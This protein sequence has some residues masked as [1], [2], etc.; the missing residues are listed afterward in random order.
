MGLTEV[1]ALLEHDALARRVVLHEPRVDRV[2]AQNE[3]E[4]L[5][6]EE[7]ELARRLRQ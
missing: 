4:V 6:L 5:V 7:A 1:A 3:A 2:V